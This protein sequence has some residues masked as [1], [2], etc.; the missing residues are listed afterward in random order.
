MTALRIDIHHHVHLDPGVPTG[1]GQQ[2]LNAVEQL[3]GLIAMNMQELQAALT[4]LGAQTNKV[5]SEVSTKLDELN[6]TIDTLQQALANA[7]NTTPEVDALVASLK[8]QLT[9]IDNLIPD[10]A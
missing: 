8:G 1:L 3:R 6:T 9:A 5:F 7:G 4:E 10:Q 2:I